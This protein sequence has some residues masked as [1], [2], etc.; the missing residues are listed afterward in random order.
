MPAKIAFA[1][2]NNY[3]KRNKI[4]PQ[5]ISRFLSAYRANFIS[6]GPVG[7]ER[8]QNINCRLELSHELHLAI[9]I[10]KVVKCLCFLLKNVDYCIGRGAALELGGERIRD[11]VLPRL[12]GV[13][14]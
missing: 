8:K 13:L 6:E 4:Y 14:V 7:G 1:G 11:D 2:G 5:S 10:P 3:K 9:S 12:L